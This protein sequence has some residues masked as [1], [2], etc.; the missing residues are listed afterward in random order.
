[1]ESTINVTCQNNI[2]R[3]KLTGRVDAGNASVLSEELKK[4]VGQPL[5]QIVFIVDELEY[6]SSAG[7]RAIIFAKQKIGENSQVLLIAPQPSVL[8][9]IKMSGLDTFVIIQDSFK[10]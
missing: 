1:M 2:A 6:M 9:V 3:I 7:L 5:Q 8:E 10:E 4:L